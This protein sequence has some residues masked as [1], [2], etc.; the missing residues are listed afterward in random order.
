M[1][2]EAIEAFRDSA[3]DLLSRQNTISRLRELRDSDSGFDRAS[4]RELSNAG[5]LGVLVGEEDGGLGLGLRES[6]P[7]SPNR[8]AS[9]Y[10]QSLSSPALCRSRSS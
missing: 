7:R 2:V 1:G 4:W 3:Q 9:I 8:R 6:F 5:W 10:C